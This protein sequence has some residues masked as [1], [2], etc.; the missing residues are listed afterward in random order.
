MAE[1]KYCTNCGEA[2]KPPYKFCGR[3][4]SPAGEKPVLF[5]LEI[6]PSTS[7][8]YSKVIKRAEKDP[9][10]MVIERDG[11]IYHAVGISSDTRSDIT[12]YA[13]SFNWKRTYIRLPSGDRVEAKHASCYLEKVRT[14]FNCGSSSLGCPNIDVQ[15]PGFFDG[16]DPDVKRKYVMFAL[17]GVKD[18]P[19]WSPANVSPAW[20]LSHDEL[21]M[22]KNY[23]VEPQEPPMVV[24]TGISP[25]AK[26]VSTLPGGINIDKRLWVLPVHLPKHIDVSESGEYWAVS[27]YRK[28]SHRFGLYRA[29]EVLWELEAPDRINQIWV[30][31][32]GSVTITVGASD[33]P[34][35]VWTV[36]CG[37]S[38]KNKKT[39]D[40]FHPVSSPNGRYAVVEN[41][42]F[43]RVYDLSKKNRNYLWQW[44][45][46][47]NIRYLGVNMGFPSHDIGAPD[48]YHHQ[49]TI[50]VKTIDNDGNLVVGDRKG[51]LVAYDKVG[52]M[53]FI[54]NTRR[55]GE[56]SYVKDLALVPSGGYMFTCSM[57]K[58]QWGYFAWNNSLC[59]G[60]YLF[61]V[62]SVFIE[63]SGAFAGVVGSKGVVLVTPDGAVSDALPGSY[64]CGAVS[65]ISRVLILASNRGVEAYSLIAGTALTQKGDS[66]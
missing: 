35:M 28:P 6:G 63:K 45:H 19:G 41:W 2:L 48:R 50:S 66:A 49:D 31:D 4:G 18:C 46:N 43:V 8:N 37:G 26:E 60:S 23:E 59:E 56:E 21:R 25:S 54:K 57:F 32:E 7:E 10:H 12:K 39:L 27:N 65:R 53:L 62:E 3:C 33:R 1:Q 5:Y 34:K 9:T 52:R 20:G 17:N 44:P 61:D 16:L 51:N 30:D 47:E 58:K 55:G 14:G 24:T 40:F 13:P 42:A 22:L 38:C 36:D 29:N 15:D 11:E 64:I